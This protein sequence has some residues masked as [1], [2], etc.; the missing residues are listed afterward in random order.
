MSHLLPRS[1]APAKPVPAQA[2]I[3]LKFDHIGEILETTPSVGWL[4]VHAENYMGDG[5]RPLELL[6]DISRHYPVSVHGVGL[7]I[8]GVDDLDETHLERFELLIDRVRPGLVSE[9][10]AWCSIGGSHF[11]DLLP[12]PYTQEALDIVVRHVDQ[13]QQRIGRRI[14]IEN[15]SLYVAFEASEMPETAFLNALTD[16]TGC[17]LVLDVNN[18]HVSACNLGY[19]SGAYIEALDCGPVGEIHLAGHH[20][21]DL[22]DR[23]LL[24][25]DHAS[26][27]CDAVW[28]LYSTTL[29]RTGPVPSLIEWDND[30]PDLAVLVEE[31]GKADAILETFFDAERDH[32]RAA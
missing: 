30:V 3:G 17:G 22:G 16:R 8:G 25:D 1:T 32:V 23:T 10:L 2:G 31:V 12:L 13:V 9:H 27:V 18:V 4:E 26:R 19:D 5:G 14:L 11:S 24:I 6:A 7:S 21:K 20:L 15:P 29:R 28:D